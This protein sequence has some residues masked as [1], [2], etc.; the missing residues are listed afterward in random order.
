MLTMKK[1]MELTVRG[2]FTCRV[3]AWDRIALAASTG[4]STSILAGLLRASAVGELS[5]DTMKLGLSMIVICLFRGTTCMLLE[6]DG[7]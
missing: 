7:N 3:S 4:L 5:G 1:K 2:S 6:Q